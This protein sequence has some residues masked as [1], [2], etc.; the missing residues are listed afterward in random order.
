M[1]MRV[2]TTITA[3]VISVAVAGCGGGGAAN[4]SAPSVGPSTPVV[5]PPSGSPSATPPLSGPVDR[6]AAG[7][8]VGK[9]S[10]I[11]TSPRR[12]EIRLRTW[13]DGRRLNNPGS[14][15]L[16]VK[17]K[18]RVRFESGR[19]GRRK[20]LSFAAFARRFAETSSRG[21][22]L[23]G[24]RY[25]IRVE[26]KKVT[27]I[28]E[29][30]PPTKKTFQDGDE[31]RDVQALQRR[32]AELHYDVGATDGAFG[33]DTLHAVVAFQKVN[34]MDRTGVADRA[35]WKALYD[36]V[37]AKPAHKGHGRRIEVDL[38]RQ[39]LFLIDGRSVVRIVDVSTGGGLQSYADGSQHVAS[40]PTGDFH[41][42]Q[43]IPG[44]YESSVGPMYQSN[45]FATHIA[46]HGSGSVPTYPASHGCVRVTVPAMDRL[47]PELSIGMPVSV[48][49]S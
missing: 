33:Y 6:M 41:I 22:R 8:Y 13:V 28:G 34:R 32:L 24:L 49:R 7:S 16:A 46:I 29:Y 15:V 45:F 2:R 36:P 19:L 21:D 31:G 17:S 27:A 10:A 4:R 20:P 9:V 40:T 35:V 14:R 1:A 39:V 11:G 30:G 18:T 3:L 47:L 25:R 42:F 43:Y 44:W 38:T 26:H 37:V 23:Q 5:T 12:I 48:Y